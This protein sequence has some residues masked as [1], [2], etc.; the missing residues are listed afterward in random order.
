MTS[1]PTLYLVEKFLYKHT[2]KVLVQYAFEETIDVKNY[3][4]PLLL[5]S[6]NH[7]TYLLVC[8]VLCPISSSSYL[9]Y[10]LAVVTK[11]DQKRL[12]EMRVRIGVR[13]GAGVRARVRV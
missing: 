8:L 4:P 7:I 5:L 10:Y 1:S 9:A 12:A 2:C 3:K 11:D 6:T 13:T